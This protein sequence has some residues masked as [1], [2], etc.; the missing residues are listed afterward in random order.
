MRVRV[1]LVLVLLAAFGSWAQAGPITVVDTG[2]GPGSDQAG[3]GLFNNGTA[4]QWLAA[5]YGGPHCLDRFRGS[6][7]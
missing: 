7:S 5:E 2:P 1:L 6:R 3:V 4:Y